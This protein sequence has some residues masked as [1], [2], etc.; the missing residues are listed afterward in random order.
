MFQFPFPTR[1]VGQK[2]GKTNRYSTE[3]CYDHTKER[4]FERHKLKLSRGDYDM[5]CERYAAVCIKKTLIPA[6]WPPIVIISKEKDQRVFE[7]EFKGQEL[8][9]VWCQKRETITTVM[10]MD[11]EILAF[12][13]REHE[14]N[15]AFFKAIK[16]NDPSLCIGLK[17]TAMFSAG[18][19]K[20]GLKW[21]EREYVLRNEEKSE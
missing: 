21:S 20:Y 17:A 14:E 11:D 9:F 15:E 3:F 12:L 19:K 4:M 2:M 6:S 7:T 5:L 16:E 18:V 10:C 13:K 1:Y 8:R